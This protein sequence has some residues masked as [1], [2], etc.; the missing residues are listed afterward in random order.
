MGQFKHL[1]QLLRATPPM[2]SVTRQTTN[3]ALHWFTVCWW[4]EVESLLN[5][6]SDDSQR[7]RHRRG[8]FGVHASHEDHCGLDRWG[9]LW[10]LRWWRGSSRDSHQ[11]Q[12]PNYLLINQIILIKIKKWAEKKWKNKRTQNQSK[13]LSAA[14]THSTNLVSHSLFPLFHYQF[15]MLDSHLSTKS[16][17]SRTKSLWK[18]TNRKVVGRSYHPLCWS[19][20]NSQNSSTSTLSTLTT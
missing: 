4:V 14:S 10:Q 9:G 13:A 20:S 8:H 19:K 7:S 6:L 1:S 2:E 18:S 5:K 3:Q 12:D 16:W 15:R 11:D 17:S